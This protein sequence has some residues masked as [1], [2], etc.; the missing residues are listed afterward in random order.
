MRWRCWFLSV[1]C[2]VWQVIVYANPKD[3]EVLNQLLKNIHTMQAS[4][5]QTMTDDKG[6][7]IQ[8]VHGK[9]LLL[10]PGQFRWETFAPHAKLIIAKNT[11]LS[12]YDPDLEQVVIRAL[13]KQAGETPALF[14][15]DA[16]PALQTDFQVKVEQNISGL[17]SFLLKP[18]NA[19][20]LFEWIYLVFAKGQLH[21]MLIQDHLGYKTQI[22]F[23]HMRSNGSV[24]A[25]LFNF[26]PPRHVDIIDETGR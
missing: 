14:L 20:S 26:I 7:I 25:R 10:R 24:A 19:G 1:L 2:L 9:M 12:I 17:Q 22:Q 15:S 3:A 18:K 6:K 21:S 4:F 16:N 13:A 23:S 5:M 8:Q 11:R